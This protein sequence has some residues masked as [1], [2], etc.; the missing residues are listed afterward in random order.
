MEVCSLRD[1]A[2]DLE[3]LGIQV[4]G[5]SFDDV[6][7]QAAFHNKQELAFPLLSD[8]DGSAAKKYAVAM[9]GRPFARRVTFIIDDEG[10][11]RHIDEK[12][13]VRSHGSDLATLVEGLQD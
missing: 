3:Q 11:L 10:V 7:A 9:Q 2:D 13:S 12:V 4:Y 1:A 8:P 6:L 5:V